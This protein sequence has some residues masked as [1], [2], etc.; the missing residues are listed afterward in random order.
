MNNKLI[1]A[2]IFSILASFATVAQPPGQPGGGRP[3][4]PQ[5]P[6]GFGGGSNGPGGPGLERRG[7]PGDWLKLLDTNKNGQLDNDELNSAIA[8]TFDELDRDHDGTIEPSESRPPD[9]GQPN[10]PRPNVNGPGGGM[11][12]QPRGGM[13][14]QGTGPGGPNGPGDG[15]DD[16]KRL[17]PRFFFEGRMKG[18]ANVTKDEFTAIVR[19]TFNE[20][21]KNGDGALTKDEARPPKRQ[22]GPPD[23]PPP[24]P[25]APN[26]E[27][28][29]A[30][31]RFGDKLITGQPF[32][33]ESVFEDTRRLYDGSTVTKQMHGAFYRDTAGRTRREQPLEQVGGFKVVG[34][35]NKPQMLVF[36]NDFGSKTQYFLDTNNKIAHKNHIGPPPPS[37]P[38]APNGTKTESLGTKTIEGVSCEGTRET[39]EIPAGQIG[40]DK[41]LQVVTEIWFSPELGVMVMSRHVDP[42]GGEHVF[43]LINIKRGEPSADLFTVPSGYRIEAGPQPRD[44]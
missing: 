38:P 4:P 13:M 29:G 12:G 19:G 3:Q 33:A 25:P 44:E 39:F 10:G 23:M 17:L 8:R 21:D 28:I 37:E 42:L 20:M 36:I 16:D 11:P 24:P 1:V 35:D 27:F 18:D 30:E 7:Q 34:S 15:P 6:G 26:A 5:G 22:D 41:P 9:G 43:K 31:L 14:G 2:F 32:S 40:N